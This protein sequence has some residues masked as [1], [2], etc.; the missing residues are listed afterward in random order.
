[1]NAFIDH[2]WQSLLFIALI[3]LLA[4]LARPQP[5]QLRLWLWRTAAV[6]LLLP[7]AWVSALG[8]WLGFPVRFPGDPPPPSLVKLANEVSRAFSPSAWW[9]SLANKLALG[10]ILLLAMLA[11]ARFILGR[12]HVEAL[13]ARVEELRLE[14]DPDDREPSLGFF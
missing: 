5:A 2:L 13:R 6:K 11:A 3:G 10:V 4:R 14:T 9:G 1:M 8:S 7:F 12:I